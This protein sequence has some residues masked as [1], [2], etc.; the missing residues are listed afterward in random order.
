M[1][2][3]GE[4]NISPYARIGGN[5]RYFVCLFS[6]IVLFA[7]AQPKLKQASPPLEL[8]VAKPTKRSMNTPTP[9]KIPLPPPPPLLTPKKPKSYPDLTKPITITVKDAS[10][11]QVILSLANQIGINIVFDEDVEDTKI[12]VSFH[13]VPFGEALRA[14]LMANDLYFQ[15]YPGY[16]RVSRMIT[17]FFHINYVISSRQGQSNTEVSLS[18]GT[19]SGKEN[20]AQSS[21]SGDISVVSSEVVN[22]WQNFENDLKEIL[23]DPLYNI[24]QAEYNRKYLQQQLSL[25]PYQETYQKEMQKQQIEMLSLQKAILK[26][27][28]EEGEISNLQTLAGTAA[29]GGATQTTTESTTTSSTST[30]ETTSSLLGSYIIDP[31]TGT[32][33][34]TTTPEVMK[35]VEEFIAK[36]KRNLSRQVLI[37]VQILEVN[38]DKTHQIGI[39]WSQF[40]GTIEFFKLPQLRNIINSQ[41]LSQAETAAGG[42]TGTSQTGG[43]SSPLSTS[44]FPSSPGAS[45]QVGVLHS[46]TPSVSYQWSTNALISFLKTQ[47]EVKAISRPQLLTLNNQ[48][49]LVSVG[50]ND[51]YITYEQATTSAQAGLATSTVTSKLNPIFIGVT[52]NITP[53]ISASGEIILK[54]VPVINKKVGE[55]SVPTGIASAPT[56]TIPIIETRQTSTIVRAKD[57]QPIII[58]GLIQDTTT[59]NAKKLPGLGNI[60][61]LG[62][63]FRYK[64]EERVRSELVIVL[65]PHIQ[66]AK[67]KA[68]GY[69]HIK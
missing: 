64:T 8:T 60:P 50:T 36:V 26:K 40:P 13:H 19:S 54:I 58:S 57:G 53:Q 2:T 44:P 62:H 35:R 11:K 5:M 41:M 38:L 15:P 56:Q 51:F 67:L 21:T 61:I 7:C 65:T 47:G 25:L 31:Q 45:L 12:N 30:T 32:V 34:V 68:L 22:F 10:L 63:I 27:Q 14:I 29:Q 66:S 24:L 16:I 9:S 28:L 1:A 3:K 69:E 20:I 59:H 52:L 46:L 55:K 23:K 39:D 37:D 48:P 42:G 18:S 43:I 17:K 33:V 49:A 4:E 6:L